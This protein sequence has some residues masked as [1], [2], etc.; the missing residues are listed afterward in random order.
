[1]LVVLAVGVGAVIY[2]HDRTGSIYHPHAPFVAQPTPTLKKG[3]EPFSWPFY[4]YTQNHT[5][6]FPAPETVR[7]PFKRLWVH[8]AGRP[9]RVPAGDLR[10][11]HLPARRQR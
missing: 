10:R 3:P 4:G 8:N 5:R 9:A 6:F 2:K 1:M 7:P 11:P